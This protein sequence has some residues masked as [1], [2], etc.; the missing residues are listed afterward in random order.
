M[1]QPTRVLLDG[2]LAL[3]K[4]DATIATNRTL[5]N[6][7]L[8]LLKDLVAPV[9]GSD[10]SLI[11]GH[12]ATYSGYARVQPAIVNGPFVGENS[13][14]LISGNATL[15]QPSDTITPNT[16]YGHFLLGDDS[17]TLL[18]VELFDSPIPLSG[19]ETGFVDAPI[20]GLG[21]NLAGYGASIV[22]G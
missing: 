21:N 20:I 8:G 11:A 15:F 17:T 2:F 5:S 7:W 6:C 22:S 10:T 4:G 9:L 16:I 3:S 14:S 1:W 12:E 13:F 19:P 18:A